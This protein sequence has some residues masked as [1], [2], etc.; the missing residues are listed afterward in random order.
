MKRREWD[1]AQYGAHK[2]PIVTAVEG[3]DVI[4]CECCRY[5][6][7]VPLPTPETQT[8]FYE[9]AFYQE[10]K[11]GYLAEASEDFPWKAIECELRFSIVSELIG[12][13]KGRFLDVGSGPGDFLAI[14]KQL[15]WDGIGIEPSPVATRYAHSRGLEVQT[16]F[17]D[18]HVARNF[19]DLDFVHMSEV[20]EHVPQPRKLL[21]LAFETL[22]PGGILCV[23]V[24]NDY[25]D[26]QSIITKELKGKPWWVVPDH[27][28]NYFN[29]STLSGLV[30][31]CGFQVCETLT[32]FPMEL[33]L[34]MGQDY[35]ADH[36]KGRELHGWR[37]ALDIN[38]AKSDMAVMR[39]LYGGLAKAGL[40]RL[41]IVFARKPLET[42]V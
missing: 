36:A 5:K 40:G 28:L 29:F 16:G 23:S 14:G 30:T 2:G 24:P 31:T 35:T 20:L 6:H 9:E 32:N 34:L 7:V 33:F 17:F 27:H 22:K 26:L 3:V 8:E 10:E 4:E 38:L 39:R 21:E 15:G 1:D 37:K 11:S 42:D 18:E 13:T 19:T 25:N 12:D 41:A